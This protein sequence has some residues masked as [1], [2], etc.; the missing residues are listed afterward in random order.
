MNVAY[1][2]P[3]RD[4]SGYGEAN[5]HFIGAL[6]VAGVYVIPKL[7]NYTTEQSD[8]GD[9]GEHIDLL[10]SERADDTYQIKI[11]H[12]TP[13]EYSRLIEPGKYHIGHFFWETDLIPDDFA[14]AFGLID[15]IW[16]GSEAN[17]KA[18]RSAGVETFIKV[19]PQPTQVDREWPEPY[20]LPNFD[21]YLFYSIFEWTDRKNPEAL[22]EAYYRE[23]QA[24][25]NVGLLLKTYF[26]NFTLQN[27]RMIRKK[28][29]LIKSRLGF[30]S[31]P[32]IFLYL[33]LMDRRQISR[34]HSTGDC[35]V[36]AHRGEG[37]GV[38]QIEAAL[39]GK[40]FISTGYGGCHEYFTDS[41][42][43]VILPYQMIKLKGMAHSERWYTPSQKWADVDIKALH[44][45]LRSAYDEP[46]RFKE[47]GAAGQMLVRDKFNF[48]DVGKVMGSRLAEIQAKL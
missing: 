32:P 13:D 18:I 45:A 28:V 6:D 20:V 29:E 10:S 33:E 16:T 9:L 22:I 36:S 19:F 40:P 48:E 47:I 39:C 23:F 38:P 2:G 41:E 7:V 26:R 43:A 30:K 14:K 25:E 4:Y 3:F 15:E 11:M 42:N 35:Y 1:L 8:F 46:N 12:T 27:K 37:W 21:G 44:H 34:I 17:A 5:R 31:Y 24:G